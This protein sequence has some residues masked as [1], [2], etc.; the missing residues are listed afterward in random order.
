MHLIKLSFLSTLILML[1]A[2]GQKG[3]LYIN[4]SKPA[5]TPSAPAQDNSQ[6]SAEATNEQTE[7]S[8]KAPTAQ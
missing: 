2:C 5:A 3:P 6:H 1:L 7:I 4:E 8:D